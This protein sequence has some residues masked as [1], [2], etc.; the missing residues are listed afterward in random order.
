MKK[1][2][3]IGNPINHSISPKIHNYWFDENKIKANY[4]KKKLEVNQLENII[5]K[6]REKEIDGTNVTAPFKEKIISYLDELSP[7]AKE[8]NSVNT[9]YLLKNSIIGHNTDIVGFYMS[10]KNKNID[11][12]NKNAFIL[13]SGGVVASLI[14]ALKKLGIKKITISNRTKDRAVKIKEKFDFLEILDWGETIKADIIINTTSLGLK[15]TDSIDLDYSVFED[16]S[17]FYDLIYNPKE[18]KFLLSAK[19][20]GFTTLNGLMM[21]VYQAAHAF[22]IW[23]KVKPK[24]DRKL[25]TF[26]TND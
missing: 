7:E 20:Y 12:N 23:H 11:L 17:L 10:L 25:I 15:E 4:D 18:T 5:R 14:I 9:I 8:A 22:E 2:L 26:I 21:F 16:S 3:V 24:I 19:K 6:I 13:G 1:Y